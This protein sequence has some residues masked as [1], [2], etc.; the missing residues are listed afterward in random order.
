VTGGLDHY[1]AQLSQA[2]HD[3]GYLTPEQA[4]HHLESV[5]ADLTSGDL[6]TALDKLLRGLEAHRDVSS[7]MVGFIALYGSLGASQLRDYCNDANDL[8]EQALKALE[9]AAR[10]QS[11]QAEPWLPLVPEHRQSL[12]VLLGDQPIPDILRQFL[13][14]GQIGLWICDGDLGQLDND[15]AAFLLEEAIYEHL[16]QRLS[17]LDLDKIGVEILLATDPED[18]EEVSLLDLAMLAFCSLQNDPSWK[19]EL[20]KIVEEVAEKSVL[21]EE[22]LGRILWWAWFLKESN[23]PYQGLLSCAHSSLQGV[24]PSLIKAI[25]YENL[26]SSGPRASSLIPGDLPGAEL[27]V[28]WLMADDAQ[29]FAVSPAG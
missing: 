27:V 26:V 23:L 1:L 25:V 14:K 18:D 15:V 4:A 10:E 20:N 11:F 2:L 19:A 3:N 24:D 5:K 9:L 6:D 8:Q 17:A 12:L 22:H 13:T 7:D 16:Q 21:V 28:E 29:R